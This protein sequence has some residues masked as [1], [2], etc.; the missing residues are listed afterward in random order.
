MSA[1]GLGCRFTTAWRAVVAQGRTAPGEWV[2]IHGCGGVGLSAIMVARAMGARVIG[3]DIQNDALDLARELGAEVLLNPQE[4]A[5]IN[6]AILDS[7]GGGA[8]VSI[9]ALG[10]AVTCAS[11]IRCLR[12]RGRH[13]Q[14]GL[15]LGADRDHPVPMDRVIA[16]ELEIRGSHGMQAHAFAPLLAMI[17]DGAIDPGILVRRRVNLKEGA[18]ALMQMADHDQPGMTVVDRIA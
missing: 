14:V 18:H 1:A 5:G 16:N 10:S 6:E 12:K 9:D 11:S 13:I 4:T 8:A 3:I 15:M 2:A 17:A 7:T